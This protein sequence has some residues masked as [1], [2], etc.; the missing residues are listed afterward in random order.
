MSG[1]LE[2]ATGP[3]HRRFVL[4]A[5]ALLV[6]VVGWVWLS[7]KPATAALPSTGPVGV[8]VD[9]AVTTRSDVPVYLEG[10]GNV[11]A[12]YT[13][14]IT[15]RV[16]GQL[17][18][19]GFIEGQLVKKGD[20]LAQ[21]DP[22][23][24][25]AALD[26][27]TGMQAKDAAQLDSAKRDLER[28]TTLAPQNLISQQVLDTQRALVAQLQAQL[29]VDR[30]LIDNARTQLE[31]AS[32]TAPFSGRTGIRL[33]DPGNIVHA[34]DTTGIVVVT[35]IQPISVMFTLPEDVVLQI[36]QALGAG[37]VA[38]TA[39]SRDDQTQLDNGTLALVDNEI[40]PTTGTV[41]LK[42]TFPNARNTLWPGQFVNVR[43]LMQSRHDVVTMPSAAVE[44]GPDGLFAYVVKAD[45]TVEVR[46]IKTAE[47]NA[48]V[49]VVTDG[50]QPGEHVVT[51]NQYR[52]QPGAKV[53]AAAAAASSA[54]MQSAPAP[55]AD[56]Q[57]SK[58]AHGLAP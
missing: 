18:R 7:R 5:G 9:T 22:R 23:P 42:A 2:T 20:L 36:N 11:Q 35:Q 27:A 3:R 51:S 45:S 55:A 43:V 33:V 58:V 10:L 31:Y 50:L 14:K 24:L 47:D 1:F 21:I 56:S 17:Q 15:A 32:I 4:G 8:A 34:A 16:D 6:V 29:Q 30:A 41:R 19:V 37:A 13:A 44:H 12:F 25:Q 28:Y 49:T 46:P 57:P 38:V 48:G 54:N 39:L 52:L 53:R 26:Q 40:D